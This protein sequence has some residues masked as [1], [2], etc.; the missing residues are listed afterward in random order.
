MKFLKIFP[1]LF[2]FLGNFSYINLIYA[3]PENPKNYK[4][5]SSNNKKL[6]IANV[7]YYLKQGDTF[8]QS[9]DLDNAK[10]LSS[11]IINIPSSAFL[12]DKK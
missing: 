12:V 7:E 2:I 9:G 10:N 5:L 8:I 3:G 1:I 6:S 4:V 11:K